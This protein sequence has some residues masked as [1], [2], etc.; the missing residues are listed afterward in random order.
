[1]SC[2][3]VVDAAG[4][5]ALAAEAERVDGVAP[6]SEAFV[7]ALTDPCAAVTHL[8][9]HD[10]PRLTGYAQVDTAGAAE[11]A[12]APAD[13]RRGHGR[14]LWDQA[15]AAGARTV[16]AHGDLPA[17]AAFAAAVGLHRVRELHR[18]ERPL[19]E[20]DRAPANLPA[21][22]SARTFV[23]GADEEAWLVLNAAAFA[24]HPEQGRLTLDDLHRR[25]AQPWFDADGFFLVA[26]D[27]TS[28]PVAFH[29]TKVP[30]AGSDAGAHA[31]GEVY[32]VGVH[33]AYQGRGL[34][35]PLTR[36]GTS[37]LARRGLTT[38]ELYVD[39]DN[40]AALATYRREGFASVAVDAMYA[41]EPGTS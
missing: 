37:H 27:A 24:H 1:M 19:T 9:A 14:R 15:L 36:L 38:V 8:T 29:W 21:G 7:L 17:A 39:G 35:R 2:R 12:V 30:K 3:G 13:R 6:L 33:P 22:F 25:M 34:A 40:T 11:L 41:V 18:M 5:Q 10:G 28:R 31:V 20:A 23:P 4:V 32:V 16:W 26:E